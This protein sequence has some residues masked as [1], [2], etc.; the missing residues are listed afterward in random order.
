MELRRKGMAA[1]VM[2]AGSNAITLDGKLVNL[3][4]TGNRPCVDRLF[5]LDP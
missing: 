3:D 4:G 5:V 2:I 1:D